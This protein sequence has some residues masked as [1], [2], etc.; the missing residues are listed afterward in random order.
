L[1]NAEL[2]RYIEASIFPLYAQ[3]DEGHRLEHI[4]TVLKRCRELMV[5]L[6][7]EADLDENMVFAIA[8]YHDIGH[9]ID[10]KNHE[11]I[12]AEI[13]SRDLEMRKFFTDEQRDIIR[14][15]IADHRASAALKPGSIY[16]KLISSADRTVDIDEIIIR[17]YQYTLKHFPDMT[18]EENK[19]RVYQHLRDKYGTD[20]YAKMWLEDDIYRQYKA[21]IAQLISDP[22]EFDRRFN[23]AE[24]KL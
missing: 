14:E 2:Q 9:H 13:F 20:G 8:A 6:G 23:E 19:K 7:S 15:A 10:A 17:T 12:S 3:N 22:D 21:E 16:G 18:H 11:K 5:G 4:Q 1:I 24:N